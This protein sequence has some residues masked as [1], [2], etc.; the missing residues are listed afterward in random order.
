LQV[1]GSQARWA[2]GRALGEGGDGILHQRLPESLRVFITDVK[3]DVGRKDFQLQ[4][5]TSWVEL[6]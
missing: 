2:R 1:R 4:R 5:W 3:F 6:L